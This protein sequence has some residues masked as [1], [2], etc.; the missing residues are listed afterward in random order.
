MSKSYSI[1][2]AR[3][4]FAAIVRDVELDSA[5]EVTRRGEPVAVLL[6][7]EEY[8]RLLAGGRSFWD[9]YSEFRDE[10]DLRQLN[11]EPETFEDLRDVS[12]GRETSWHS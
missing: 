3:N 2:E 1:A 12:P 6:S 7:I 4:N 5:I 9:A 10:V 8:R 11:I